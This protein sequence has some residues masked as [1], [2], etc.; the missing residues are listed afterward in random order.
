MNSFLGRISKL[1]FIKPSS[2]FV[3]TDLKPHGLDVDMANYIGAK[4]GAVAVEQATG[5]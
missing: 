3:S 4:L 2:L 5:T 1:A